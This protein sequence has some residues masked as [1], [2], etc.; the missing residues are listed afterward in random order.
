M[1][2]DQCYVIGAR[3]YDGKARFE[4]RVRGKGEWEGE[5]GQEGEEGEG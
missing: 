3:A 5:E 4:V 2:H 1:L